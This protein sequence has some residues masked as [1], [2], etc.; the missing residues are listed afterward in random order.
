MKV[1][2]IRHERN[3]QRELGHTSYHDC[4]QFDADWTLLIGR[5]LRNI[6][7]GTRSGQMTGA[8]REELYI[9]IAALAVA[10]IEAQE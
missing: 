2:E 10:A 9:H 3:R 8:R 1:A 5:R 4:R 7:S 6:M